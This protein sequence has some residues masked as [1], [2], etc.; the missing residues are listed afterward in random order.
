MISCNHWSHFITLII[1]KRY[2][3]LQ[4]AHER[5]K[6]W[7]ISISFIFWKE[8]Q[9]EKKWK[10]R[11][12]TLNKWA[13][14]HSIKWKHAFYVLANL[15]GKHLLI[16]IIKRKEMRKINFGIVW[17]WLPSS[18]YFLGLGIISFFSEIVLFTIL[19]TSSSFILSWTSLSISSILF[20]IISSFSFS[21]SGFFDFSK[22]L[23]GVLKSSFILNVHFW[24]VFWF[25]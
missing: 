17:I 14:L 4:N 9:K 6:F 7:F 3:G 11:R 13:F 24:L 8:N 20:S 22:D 19:C 18:W 12:K 23:N 16:E 5:S 15:D 10:V 25:Y 1:N 21:C 2:D